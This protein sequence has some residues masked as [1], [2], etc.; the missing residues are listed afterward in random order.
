MS[1]FYKFLLRHIHYTDEARKA[2]LIA[3]MYIQFII[4]E[5]GIVQE[6]ELMNR[7]GFGLDEEVQKALLNSPY[8]LPGLVK[9]EPLKTVMILSIPIGLVQ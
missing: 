2:G 6:V 4:D 8:W 3:K 5:N 7:I 1:K 9:N